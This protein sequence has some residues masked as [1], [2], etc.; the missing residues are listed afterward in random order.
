MIDKFGRTITK[1]SG[2]TA[3]TY[4]LWDDNGKKVMEVTAKTDEKAISV[5]EAHVPPPVIEIVQTIA[6]AVRRTLSIQSHVRGIL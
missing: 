6:Q 5:I 4:V 2:K 3:P 1:V